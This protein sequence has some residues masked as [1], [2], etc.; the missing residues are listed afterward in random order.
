MAD[1][2][3]LGGEATQKAASFFLQQSDSDVPVEMEDYKFHSSSIIDTL[4]KLLG[5]FRKE[6]NNVDAEEVK[7]VQAHDMFTQ[8]RTDYVKAQ[9]LQLNEAKKDRDEKIEDIGAA[10]QELSTVS[11]QLLD[12]MQYLDELNTVCSERAKTWDQRPKL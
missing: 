3:G 5:D 11:A 2:L 6:K 1:A 4:E 12:D 8:D 9:T 10:S 7:R